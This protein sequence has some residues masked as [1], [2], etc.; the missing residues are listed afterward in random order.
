MSRIFDELLVIASGP[1]VEL[2]LA[3]MH[4]FCNVRFLFKR[5][6]STS[7]PYFII[8]ISLSSSCARLFLALIWKRNPFGDNI[9]SITIDLVTSL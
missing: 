3:G 6:P 9:T 8:F 2:I 5:N 1:S 4:L 7:L